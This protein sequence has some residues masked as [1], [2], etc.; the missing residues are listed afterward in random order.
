M[1][2]CYNVKDYVKRCDVCLASKVVC[3][4]L[5]GDLQSLPMSIY[6]WKDLSIDFITGL[7]ILTDWKGDIYGSILVIV[8]QL[9][10]KIYYKLVKVIIDVSSLTEIIIDV[11]VKHYSLPDSIV[12]NRGSL[13]TSKFWSLLCYYLGMKQRLFTTFYLQTNG[14]TKRQNTIIEA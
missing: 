14:Q 10:K 3:H 2:L 4:K 12:I 11:V 8:N 9:T 1:L 7:Q 6:R 13:F 5:Y